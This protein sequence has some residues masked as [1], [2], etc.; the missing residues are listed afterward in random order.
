MSAAF[1][2]YLPQ[3]PATRPGD[4]LVGHEILFSAQAKAQEPVRDIVAEAEERGRR[5]ALAGAKAEADH[6][7][8]EAE[9]AFE[10]RMGNER[11]RWTEAQA[12]R[13]AAGIADG[14]RGIETRLAADVARV[15]I[16]FLEAS[17]RQK[18][19]NDLTV[20]LR[21]ILAEGR[22]TGL[23]MTGP[24]D[25]L[26]MVRGR[27]GADAASVSYVVDEAADVHVAGGE[28]FIETQLRAWTDRLLGAL[29]ETRSG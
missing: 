20:T 17:M 2:R 11:R 24:E 12:D 27:L 21:E 8:A 10:R 4:L 26:A 25:L 28:T 16:P 29:A 19:I 3:F 15:L 13:L 6:E 22:N 14:L 5:E 18:A 1:A 9:V 23:T 7:R